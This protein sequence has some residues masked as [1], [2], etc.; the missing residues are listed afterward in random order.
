MKDFGMRGGERNHQMYLI[1]EVANFKDSKLELWRDGW[2]MKL[3][4]HFAGVVNLK[5]LFDLGAGGQ[6]AGIIF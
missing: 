6:W 2:A 3:K 5:K 4:F 1:L